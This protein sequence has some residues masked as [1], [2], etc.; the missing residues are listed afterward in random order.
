MMDA[1][2]KDEFGNHVDCSV[3]LWGNDATTMQSNSLEP[4]ENQG[5][6]SLEQQEARQKSIHTTGNRAINKMA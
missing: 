3:P 4:D 6:G 1:E 2:D 5:F